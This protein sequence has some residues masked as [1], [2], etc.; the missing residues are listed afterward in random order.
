MFEHEPAVQNIWML[1][2]ESVKGEQ[3]SHFLI[4]RD[5]GASPYP[6]LRLEQWNEYTFNADTNGT[7]DVLI[8]CHDTVR[9]TVSPTESPTEPFCPELFVRTCCDPVYTEFDGA[10]QAS[11]HRGGKNMWTNGNNGY[12]IYYTEAASGNYWSIRSEDADLIWVESAEDNYQ[13]P[14]WDTYW[15]LQN[16]PLDDLT[17]MVM[18][19]CSDSFSPSSFPTNLPTK[20]PTVPPTTLEPTPMPTRDPTTSPTD[21][22]TVS[23]TEACIALEITE[24]TGTEFKYD[25]TYARAPD[26]KNGKTEWVNYITGADVY[27]IDRG[28]WSNTWIIRADVY[29]ID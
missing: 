22:P 10:Y 18:I 7:S 6:P 3:D 2:F 8:D 20:D 28:I 23:P 16:H 13:Y 4:Y 1:G 12:N 5:S 14:P 21:T 17:V 19:N 15:D 29:W 27:W 26:M 24:L 25:G 11:A 9:P